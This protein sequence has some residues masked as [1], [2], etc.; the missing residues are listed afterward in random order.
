MDFG[1]EAARAIGDVTGGLVL[2][3]PG[4]LRP[5]AGLVLAKRR[6]GGGKVDG[7]SVSASGVGGRETAIAV[8]AG[9]R[10]LGRLPRPLGRRQDALETKGH[11]RPG[12]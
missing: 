7:G 8:A 5:H 2:I 6:R 1:I 4:L 3:F 11:A 10:L 12:A 9:R